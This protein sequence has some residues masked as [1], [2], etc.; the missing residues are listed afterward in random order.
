LTVPFP[1]INTFTTQIYTIGSLMNI[2]LR[3]AVFFVNPAWT[4][5]RN[6]NRDYA[7]FQWWQVLR[8]FYFPLP[9]VADDMGGFVEGAIS[10]EEHA[11]LKAAG[12]EK[13]KAFPVLLRGA[14]LPAQGFVGQ[15][16]PGIFISLLVQSLS[17]CSEAPLT[18]ANSSAGLTQSR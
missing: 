4:K 6:K 1:T 11:K 2:L 18:D 5:P 14:Y 12:E 15:S 16:N 8:E 17:N 7:T 9:P 13:A 3:F 10:E